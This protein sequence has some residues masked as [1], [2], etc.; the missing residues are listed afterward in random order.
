MSVLPNIWFKD[1]SISGI[2]SDLLFFLKFSLILSDTTI[3][4]FNEYPITAK[5]AAKTVKSKS[6]ENKENKPKTIKTS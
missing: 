5:T 1:L 6:I 2:A 4:S 3:V